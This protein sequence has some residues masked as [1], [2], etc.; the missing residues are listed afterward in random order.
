MEKLNLTTGGR[1]L[2]LNDFQVMQ[3]EIYKAIEGQ[4]E[5]LAPFIMSGCKI[6]EDEQNG[7]YKISKGLVF[8]EGQLRVVEEQRGLQ[9]FPKYL[10]ASAPHAVDF[11]RLKSGGQAPKRIRYNAEYQNEEPTGK[12]FIKLS[13]EAPG[14]TYFDVIPHT[15]QQLTNKGAT[16]TN[17]IWL[18]NLFSE[19]K[20]KGKALEIAQSIDVTGLLNPSSGTSMNMAF[21][22]DDYGLLRARNWESDEWKP[23]QYQAAEHQFSEGDV[24]IDRSLQINGNFFSTG[25]GE[26]KDL[27]ITPGDNQDSFT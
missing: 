21:S 19:G 7:G 13:P 3:D 18:N 27:K 25:S 9:N 16:T 24:K 15:L 22:T 17:D 14:Q 20:I 12:D 1:M 4:F 2:H 11:Y 26:F 10:V 8:I 5:E 23:I 6:T